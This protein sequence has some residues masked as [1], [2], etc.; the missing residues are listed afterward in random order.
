M[1]G[2]SVSPR[3]WLLGAVL[4]ACT[5]AIAAA[6][7]DG[8]AGS[9]ARLVARRAL[10]WVSFAKEKWA[11]L[12]FMYNS[13][14]LAYQW[15]KWLSE[16]NQEYDISTK[17]G[18]FV[19][20]VADYEE[21]YEIRGRASSVWKVAQDVSSDVAGAVG[22]GV[23]GLRHD[24]SFWPRDRTSS[25]KE[26]SPLLDFGRRFTDAEK[27]RRRRRQPRPLQQ[28]SGTWWP[29]ES[30]NA[31]RAVDR[32]WT[33]NNADMSPLAVSLITTFVVLTADHIDFTPFITST[34]HTVESLALYY[35]NAGLLSLPAVPDLG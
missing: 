13:G 27:N 2:K 1:L 16:V 12:A 5:A 19:S 7:S 29:W 20:K 11:E 8:Y 14:R 6:R 34:S 25:S 30:T 21:K 32:G 9:A 3:L 28:G 18:K 26:Q 17:W 4:G 31:P 33:S 22:R 10:E 35:I 23:R 15:D 24:E